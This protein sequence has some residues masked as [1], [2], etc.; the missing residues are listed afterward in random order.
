M[1]NSPSVAIR[2]ATPEDAGQLLAIYAPYVEKTAITFEYQVPDMDEFQNRSATPTWLLCTK[3]GLQATLTHPPSSP[4][5]PTA[6]PQKPPSMWI[7]ASAA[8][9]SED[10]C[11]WH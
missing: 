6:G 5:L 3:A 11:I 9:A 8:A 2:M 1:I 4:E 10:S 7:K